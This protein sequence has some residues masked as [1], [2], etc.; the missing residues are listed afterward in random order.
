M[1]IV[2]PQVEYQTSKDRYLKY[3]SDGYPGL[4]DG[5]QDLLDAMFD[6]GFIPRWSCA[7]HP[8][9][10]DYT[11][12]K[13]GYV[14]FSSLD[15]VRSLQWFIRFSELVKEVDVRTP[16]KFEYLNYHR[17]VYRGDRDLSFKKCWT[18]CIRWDVRYGKEGIIEA[19]AAALDDF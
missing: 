6:K 17:T 11:R 8:E 9:S 1:T 19:L 16:V 7:S 5:M 15:P 2:D 13:G 12:S 10:D 4:D 3:Q 18:L 14:S